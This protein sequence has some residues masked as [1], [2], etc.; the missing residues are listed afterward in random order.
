MINRKKCIVSIFTLGILTA[1]VWDSGASEVDSLRYLVSFKTEKSY[2]F[3]Y[4]NG[5]FAADNLKTSSGTVSAGL[6]AT[7]YLENGTNEIMIK[8]ASINAP[9]DIDL[10]PESMCELVI[11]A[12]TPDKQFNIASVVAS[13]DNNLKPTGK[14]TPEYKGNDKIG[15]VK[16]GEQKDSILYVVERTF[17]A[18]LLPSWV[19][20]NATPFSHTPENVQR[21][22]DKYLDLW[23]LL[24]RND[25]NKLEEQADIAMKELASTESMDEHEYWLT[26]GIEQE[27]DGGMKAMPID[28][29][30]Y[31]VKTYKEGRL[32]RLED[33]AGRTPLKLEDSDSIFSYNPYLSIVNGKFV[34]TR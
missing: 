10:M 8:M 9:N 20:V 2:C 1:G 15:A 11:S 6:N 28:W 4:I 19:W 22:K 21:L 14:E 16:E 24:Q 34:I 30:Q 13:A 31:K 29:S 5:F 7:P 3:A 26:I 27:M 12:N 32:V 18:K 17:E 33:S 25:I 23:L